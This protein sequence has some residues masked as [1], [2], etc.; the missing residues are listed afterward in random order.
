[1]ASGRIAIHSAPNA[2]VHLDASTH[3]VSLS[4]GASLSAVS[5]DAYGAPSLALLTLN[6]ASAERVHLGA[7]AVDHQ[8]ATARRLRSPQVGGE[9]GRQSAGAHHDQATAVAVA[10]GLVG[11]PAHATSTIHRR[12]RARG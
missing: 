6:S 9:L 7:G 1:V 5:L 4:N 12:T 11:R 10:G 3:P 2:G 8:A